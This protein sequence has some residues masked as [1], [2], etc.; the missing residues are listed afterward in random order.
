MRLAIGNRISALLDQIDAG[1]LGK[2]LAI[3]AAVAL[4]WNTPVVYPLKLLV[5]FLH[6]LSHGVAAIAT[7]GS[8]SR[9][10]LT[11][12]EAGVCHTRG[13]WRFFVLSAGYLGSLAWGGAILLV[14]ARTNHDKQITMGLGILLAVVCLLYVRN[15]FG[16]V[17]GLAAAA[18]FA[19]AAKYLPDWGNDLLLKTV[20]LTSCIYAILD[21]KSDILSR[22]HMRSDARMLAEQTGIPT[23][24]W[25]VLWIV[26]AALGTLYFLAQASKGTGPPGSS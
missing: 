2:L 17:F 24:V 10:E 5:V 3:V 6:E 20:G 11:G 13:G 8:I 12:R 7:G 4:L 21:I 25:G 14:A 23:L 22:S 26:I 15:A 19:A 1:M 16:L 9:I 18:G